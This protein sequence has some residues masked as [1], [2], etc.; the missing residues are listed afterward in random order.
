M[1]GTVKP[2]E[3]AYANVDLETSVFE[4]HALLKELTQAWAGIAAG[5]H[6]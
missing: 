1:F 6:A 5:A 2:G 4:V 3:N